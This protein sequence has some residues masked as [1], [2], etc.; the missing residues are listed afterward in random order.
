MRGN[1]YAK[2]YGSYEFE[3]HDLKTLKCMYNIGHGG[4]AKHSCIYCMHTRKKEKLPSGGWSNGI[5]SCKQDISPNQD[6]M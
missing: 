2:G 5:M 4:N 3:C 6:D 1:L